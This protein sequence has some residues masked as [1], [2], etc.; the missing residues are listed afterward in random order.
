MTPA[1]AAPAP[2]DLRSDTVTRP[3]AAMRS[4]MAAAPVGDDLLDGD[5]TT[6]ALEARVA[7]LLGK[8]RA[9]YFPSGTMANQTALATLGRWGG[10]AVV[11]AGA[12]VFHYEEG[13]AA[14]LSGVQLH[15]VPTADGVLTAAHLE[16]AWRGDSRYLPRTALVCVEN[17][18]LATG[19]T[20]VP[21]EALDELGRAAHEQG[22]PVHMDGARLWHAAA[23]TGLPLTDFTRAVDTVMV[24]LSKGLGAPVGSLLAGPG[25]VLEEAWRVRRRLGGAMRQSGIIAAGGLHALEAHRER[26]VV[27]HVRAR[28]L[29]EAFDALPG[30]RAPRPAT[31][32]VMVDAEGGVPAAEALR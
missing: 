22:L 7:E 16:R 9:L 10:E 17:T 5:P 3:T 32:I 12:H 24:C 25:D 6:R 28:R 29:A 13:A 21:P 11:E 30:Y 4:A 1:G 2:V 23:E 27:D 26:L 15:P 19:G 8:E 18:H 20:I 14:A 31:N